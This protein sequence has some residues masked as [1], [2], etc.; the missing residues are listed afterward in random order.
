MEAKQQSHD[1]HFVVVNEDCVPL[2][3]LRMAQV[4][5]LSTVQQDNI[6]VASVSDRCKASSET[7][8]DVL[9]AYPKVF[10]KGRG[11]MPGKVHLQVD[12]TVTPVVMPP[13]RVPLSV[14]DRLKEELERLEKL[15]YI[16]PVVQP[17]EWVSSLVTVH[18]PNGKI[19]VCI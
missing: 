16:V 15:G 12:K 1:V 8:D 7:K 10:I 19:R 14:E 6:R 18:K 13:R 9:R 11:K 5:N 4:M 2:I 3:G 17:T